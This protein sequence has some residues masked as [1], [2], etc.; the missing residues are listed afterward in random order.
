MSRH[1]CPEHPLSG[2]S[3]FDLGHD[4]PVC[5]SC[6]RGLPRDGVPIEATV[7]EATTPPRTPSPERRTYPA[8]G[9]PTNAL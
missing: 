5:A 1:N 7:E 6:L 8:P 2:T 9:G 3:V 4:S